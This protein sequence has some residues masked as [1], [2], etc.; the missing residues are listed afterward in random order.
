MADKSSS[1]KGLHRPVAD[2][3]LGAYPQKQKGL[4][5]QRIKVL[6]GRINWRQWRKIAQL[7]TVCSSGFPLHMTTRQ[8]I[9]LHNIPAR[10]LP[11]VQQSISEVG[12]TTFGAGGDSVRNITFCSACESCS[13]GYD[14][15]PLA[16]IVRQHMERQPAI[17][18]LPRKFKISFSGCREACAKPWLNDLGFITQSEGLFTVIGAGS[19]GS[20]PALGVQLYND[21][22]ARDILPLCVAAIELFAQYGDRENRRRARFRHIRQ[23]LGDQTFRE[24]LE[25]RLTH[26]KALRSWPDVS[27]APGTKRIKL[28]YRLQLPNGNITP[29]E[30]VQL[31]DAA[32][33]EGAALR[34]NLEH[35]LE[36]CG[37]RSFE[38]PEKLAA[39][40]ANP[41]I[42]A[43]PGSVSCSKGLV[44]C[45]AA[46]DRLRD[47]LA[48]RRG[49]EL[50]INI[51]GCPNNC[52]H[53]A[54]ADIGL[55]GLLRKQ[56]G[57]IAECYRLYTG[58]GNGR[59]NRLAGQSEILSE[60]DVVPAVKRLLK[61]T[62]P[63]AAEKL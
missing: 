7:S 34:I 32:E 46:A 50:R 20:S 31:A 48:G 16:Q 11:F 13:N 33:P 44:G 61:I 52:A 51:S 10:D 54:V 30:A 38:L 9:E 57:K 25:T 60:Q 47:A 29:N 49:P 41:I 63:S 58:G 53:S 3:L 2:P 18:N 22:P 37:A 12:L 24:E 19:L 14:L 4:F 40:A 23:K 21:L 55:V 27:L 15:M 35:G 62:K 6:G 1:E 42:I 59:N 26:T 39:L 28:L 17:L 43:C 56:E 36:L 5:M 45:W 8:D